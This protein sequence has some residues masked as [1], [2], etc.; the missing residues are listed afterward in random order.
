MWRAH[1]VAKL[2]KHTHSTAIAR[3]ID[4]SINATFTATTTTMTNTHF[5]ISVKHNHNNYSQYKVGDLDFFAEYLQV[6]NRDQQQ[7][8]N[9]FL[10]FQTINAHTQSPHKH[11]YT[12][13]FFA[14]LST[15]T[16]FSLITHAILH[17]PHWFAA[18]ACFSQFICN[19]PCFHSTLFSLYR[20]ILW[21]TTTLNESM[22]LKQPFLTQY[23][24]AL[25]ALNFM[26][27]VQ[28]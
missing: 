6:F 2:H 25:N 18:Y 23:M 22:L 7:L 14:I 27:P 19:T 28:L 11:P 16:L 26:W 17:T 21:S 10:L 12:S 3:G 20:A 8:H 15:Q 1:N 13:H 4:Q 5:C 24:F 9:I